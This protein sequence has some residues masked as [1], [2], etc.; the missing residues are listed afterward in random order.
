[1]QF[2]FTLAIAI[3]ISAVNAL[4]L[5]PALSALFLKNN[6]HIGSEKPKGFK[7]K[8]FKAF[9]AGFENMTNRYSSSLRFLIKAKWVALTG[10][11]AITIGTIVLVKQTPTG[12]I[13]T[14]DQ[15]IFLYSLNMPPGASL[16]RTKKVIDKVDSII[17]TVEAVEKSY[18]VA[19]MNIITNAT[20]PISG[21]A[22]VKLKKPGTRG[23]TE[24]INAILGEVNQKL[25]V[26]SQ[27][28]LFTFTLPT[29]QGFGNTNGFELILQDRAGGKLED[30]SATAY[31]FIG[32]LMK[33]PEI[34]YAFTTF[35]T[36]NPQYKLNI[37][38]EK[39]KQLG[40]SVSELL[41]TLQVYYGSLQAGDFNRF[42]KQYKV[43]MQ[44][45]IAYRIDPSTLNDVQVNN[46]GEMVPVKTL[47][48]L[49]KVYGPE[50][51][52]RNNLFNAVTINGVPK[53]GFSS[54]EALKAIEETAATFLPR[55]YAYE[56]SSLTREEQQSGSQTTWIFVMSII[57][58][59]FLLAAQYES[60]L[61]PFAVILSVP[62]GLL[63]VFAFINFAG[64]ENNI[65]VQ[66]GIIMLIGLLAK[67]AILIVEYAVQRRKAGLSIRHAAIE[68]ATLRLRP[69][70][71]TSFAFI[72]GLIPLLTATGAS[73]MG[74]RSIGTGA[75]GGMLTGVLL[76]IFIIPVL[77]TIF[78][79]LQE[80]VSSKKIEEKDEWVMDKL[81]LQTN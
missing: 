27:A 73:A 42:G 37:D 3:L 40:V 16:E 18:S 61:L 2:A 12:F 80:K 1:K 32:E 8:F 77:F 56:W 47:V 29:V 23:K 7:A 41:Q 55:G 21:L 35:N 24:D 50:T 58:V 38:E 71:M 4:T 20:S 34:M 26:I 67:N 39:A 78:Q 6:H 45:D 72:A 22:F 15:S 54:G 43:I 9:N 81:E 68:A 19:G 70:L 11:V 63:G 31:G 65:Y 62:T 36:G 64:I 51:V 33:R 69:I 60:Y 44:S 48:N 57:F 74:N 52:T 30:L 5:S 10:L 66:V 25:S 46:I 17:G 76:G 75:V 79:Y 13:P 14:E 28:D 49:E 59:Y 53:P